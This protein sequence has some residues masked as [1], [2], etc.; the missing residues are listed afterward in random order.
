[1]TIAGAGPLSL[2]LAHGACKTFRDP[3]KDRR[4][5]GLTA[6][7]TTAFTLTAATT[8]FLWFYATGCNCL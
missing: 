1:M 5:R 2:F 6:V 3:A 7:T 8:A 4:P